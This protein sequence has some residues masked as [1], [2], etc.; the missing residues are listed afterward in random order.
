MCV[1]A[2]RYALKVY[3]NNIIIFTKNG[4]LVFVTKK[5]VKCDATL[6]V[7]EIIYNMVWSYF[8]TRVQRLNGSTTRLVYIRIY[9][10][11][12][13]IAIIII[14]NNNNNE[15]NIL[16]YIWMLNIYMMRNDITKTAHRT[17]TRI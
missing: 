10:F 7:Y 13:I 17:M 6:F 11:K 4:P 15:T 2:M 3:Y 12:D 9:G 16:L 1:T 14:H 8:F 5:D